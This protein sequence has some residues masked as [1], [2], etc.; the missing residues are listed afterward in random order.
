MKRLYPEILFRK[1]SRVGG[2]E[3]FYLKSYLSGKRRI[4]GFDKKGLPLNT[5]Q[6]RPDSD[7]SFI[8]IL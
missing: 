6:V 7:E 1:V 8:T 2:S 5:S 4:L 3:I